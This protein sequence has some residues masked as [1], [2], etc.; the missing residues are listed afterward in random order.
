MW[1]LIFPG[2]TTPQF[3]V[4]VPAARD[5]MEIEFRVQ[6]LLLSILTPRVPSVSQ[7]GKKAPILI[8]LVNIQRYN[9]YS[10]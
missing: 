8:Y 6:Q 9:Q 2:E 5:A 10:G 3:P 4:V 7:L 1:R